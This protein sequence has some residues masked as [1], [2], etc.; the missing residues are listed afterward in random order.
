MKT[1]GKRAV[2]TQAFE[3]LGVAIP[4]HSIHDSAEIASRQ[5]SHSAIS[6]V[7]ASSI[8]SSARTPGAALQRA[9][10][11]IKSHVFRVHEISGDIS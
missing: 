1:T 2:A 7:F 11:V 9:H 5:G 8:T 4:V 6:I 10:S 3:R